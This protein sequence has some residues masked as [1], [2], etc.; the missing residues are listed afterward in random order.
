ME[1]KKSLLE[2]SDSSAVWNKLLDTYLPM[3]DNTTVEE[4]DEVTQTLLLFGIMDGQINNGGVIQFIDN[5]SGNYFHETIEAAKRA[6]IDE[7]AAM[8]EK[9]ANKFP[10]GQVPKDWIER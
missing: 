10:N 2:L 6:N 5:G 4:M 7:L 8:L 1:I 9:V 3:L